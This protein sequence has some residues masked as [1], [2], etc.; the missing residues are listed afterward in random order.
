M[1]LYIQYCQ[2]L[3]HVEHSIEMLPDENPQ[4][5]DSTENE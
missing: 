3:L 2:L 4:C 5:Y 1:V